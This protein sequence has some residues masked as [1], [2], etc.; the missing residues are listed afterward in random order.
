M[1]SRRKVEANRLNA[2]M[3]TGPKTALG[4]ART[5]RN[6]RRHGL[7]VTVISDP[8]LS[9]QVELLAR[10]ITDAAADNELYQLERRIAEAQIDLVRVRQARHDFFIG[11]ID[12]PHYMSEAGEMVA[13]KTKSR[14]KLPR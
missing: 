8:V 6:A 3:S 9:E 5:A 12:D 11:L 13:P 1:V 10:E 7:S 4:K 2:R 14:Q